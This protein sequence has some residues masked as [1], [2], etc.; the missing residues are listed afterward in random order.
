MDLTPSP[1]SEA[2]RREAANISSVGPRINHVSIISPPSVIIP[3]IKPVD[4]KQDGSI[5]PG[6]GWGKLDEILKY[7]NINAALKSKYITGREI[8]NWLWSGAQP[9]CNT[10]H[11]YWAVCARCDEKDQLNNQG[12]HFLE[13]RKEESFQQIYILTHRSREYYGNLASILGLQAIK[14]LQ[15]KNSSLV[16]EYIRSSKSRLGVNSTMILFRNRFIRSDSK[17]NAGNLLICIKTAVNTD[18]FSWIEEHI[19]LVGRQTEK[20]LLLTEIIRRSKTIKS[21]APGYWKNV[22]KDGFLPIMRVLALN[23][24]EKVLS[25]DLYPELCP[26]LSKLSKL[27]LKILS[28][29]SS[30]QKGYLLG[31][32]IDR[33]LPIDDELL[34]AALHLTN[35]GPERYCR[36]LELHNNK[37]VQRICQDPGL[38][39]SWQVPQDIHLA[40]SPNQFDLDPGI[41]DQDY[42]KMEPSNRADLSLTDQICD[43]SPFDIVGVQSGTTFHFFSRGEF[44]S[45]IQ[46]KRNP[47][48]RQSLDP[49]ILVTL[50]DRINRAKLMNLPKSATLLQLITRFKKGEITMTRRPAPP[51]G[52]GSRSNLSIYS[53]SPGGH[54]HV[55]SEA[56]IGGFITFP[57]VDGP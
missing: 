49:G 30:F 31:F 24:S 4:K 48:N 27:A 16:S 8:M 37:T 9:G 52:P 7:G 36:L 53:L 15:G 32:P 43:F 38:P 42:K 51:I 28:L 26:D 33:Y 45:L 19:E 47:Y 18:Y 56:L 34:K 22:A 50:K 54:P 1:T 29:T 5:F 11:L 40:T 41:I 21:S 55:Y 25:Y 44:P 46:T 12:K 57:D 14:I 10:L 35:L 13:V 23:L 6:S 2:S 3:R 20:E 39:S 17:I